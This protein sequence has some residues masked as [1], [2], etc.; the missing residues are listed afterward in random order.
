MVES[1]TEKVSPCQLAPSVVPFAAVGVAAIVAGGLAAAVARPT[2]WS[3]G[4]WVAAYLVLVTGVGQIGLGLGQAALAPPPPARRLTI[5]LL[6]FDG[7]SLLVV[8]GTLVTAPAVVTVGGVVL[9]GALVSF[10]LSGRAPSDQRVL[11]SCY[12]GLL[13]ILIVSVPIGLAL[14]WGRA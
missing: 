8:V 4:P 13:A 12:L 7:G 5:Q 1:P 6:L 9:T 11:R 10:A 14:S 2:E 3:D